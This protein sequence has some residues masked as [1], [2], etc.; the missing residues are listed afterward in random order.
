M[1]KALILLAGL[2]LLHNDFWFWNDARLL[3]G[4]PIG[5]FYHISFCLIVTGALI[6][7]VKHLW[8]ADF[9]KE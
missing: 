9:D 1:L 3:F 5:L 2:F 7:L 8:P 4:I 6:F